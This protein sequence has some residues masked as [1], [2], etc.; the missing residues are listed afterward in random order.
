MH[1]RRT[2]PK[3]S[4]CRQLWGHQPPPPPLPPPPHRE[5]FLPLSAAILVSKVPRGWAP[6]F[7]AVEDT[8]SVCCL[9]L[10]TQGK[11]RMLLVYS[12]VP[13]STITF[14]CWSKSCNRSCLTVYPLYLPREWRFL[15]G[16]AC[17]I[18]DV[19]RVACQSRSW[20]VYAAREGS[21]WA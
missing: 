21:F 10:F 2:L 3:V 19:I 9:F 13:T 15:S 1:G 16:I 17:S 7:I 12:S 4:P 18:Y 14:A 11:E 6:G 20:L 5:R 8:F